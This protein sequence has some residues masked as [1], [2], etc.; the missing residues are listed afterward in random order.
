MLRNSRLSVHLVFWY[1]VLFVII[2]TTLVLLVNWQMRQQSLTEAERQASLLLDRNL[3]THTYFTHEL[4]PNIFKWTESFRSPDYFDPSWMSSTYAVRQM[5]KIFHQLA[6]EPYYYKES[7]INA[8]S[9]EA[10]ADDYEKGFLQELQKD[11]NLMRKTYIR[12]FDGQPYLT[13]LR[14]GEPMESSCMRCHTTPD[15]AP[16]GMVDIYGPDRSFGRNLDEVVQAISI[17]IPLAAAYA[18]ANKFSLHLSLLLLTLL[19]GGFGLLFVFTKRKIIT[20]IEQ[21]SNKA[22]LI[23]NSSE[24]LGETILEPQSSELKNLAQAFNMMSISLK[25]SMNEIEARVAERT[26][27]LRTKNVLLAEEIGERKRAEEQI[28]LNESRLQSLH[29]MSQYRAKN[30]QELLKFTLEHAIRLTGSKVGYMYHYDDS[31]QRFIL[32]TWTKNVMDQRDV[33]EPRDVYKLEE[34]GLW[35]EAAQQKKPVIVN[36]FQSYNPLEKGYPPGYGHVEFFKVLTVPVFQDDKVVAVVVVANKESDYNDSD[37][38]QLSLLMD[39]VWRMIE[40]MRAQDREQLL[41][42]AIEHA[43]EGI[44]ITDAT[45]IIQYVNS[46]EEDITGYSSGE[47]IGQKPSILKSGKHDDDLYRKLWETINAGKVWTGRFIN[48]RKDGTE[49]HE[50]ATISSV[51]NKAGDLTNFVA[52]KHDVTDHIKLQEQLIQ[53]QKMEAV[54]TL[55]G[56]ISHDFNNVLQPILGYSELLLQRKKEGE[57]D[58]ADIQKIYQAG[59][60]GADMIKSLM[61]FSRKTE[62]KFVPVDLNQ[63]ITLVQY[64]LS[65]TIPKNIKIDVHLSEVLE[66]IQGDSSQIGQVLMNL[67]VNARDAMPDGGTLSIETANI[68]LGK[69]NCITCLEEIKPGS[70]VLLTV[71]DTGQGMDKETLSHIFEPFFTTK[72]EGKGTGLGLATVYGIVKRHGGHISCYSEPGIGTSFKIYLPA[73]QTKKE[74]ETPT[75]EKAIPSGTGTILLVEDD[76]STRNLSATI[77][78]NFG[79]KVIT[80]GDGKEALE[81]YQVEKDRIDLIMLDLIMPIMDGKRCLEEILRVNPNAKVVIA[82]GYSEGG[83]ANWA[84]P[85]GAKGF[86][87]KPYDMRELLTRIREV[88]DKD[89]TG[90]D[91]G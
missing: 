56:G 81:I 75:F 77:L 13:V 15:L 14:R 50:D 43:A 38:I 78:N 33:A 60:R 47:F 73:I 55:A 1:T 5:D 40:S 32:N 23:A 86:V 16:K 64:L 12:Y 48:K 65:Q 44:I 61:T 39:S 62:T 34:T 22:I 27:E 26:A 89:I 35:G 20:P 90:P 4:K 9:P 68:Q 3:A 70:Y 24:H 28:K 37:I 36:D 79:Y 31:N 7:S 82:S 63:E 51:Y 67:G 21:I 76:E 8:R 2:A 10:E 42:A 52:V 59:L 80:A 46:A 19:L 66:S 29:E 18:G 45:G 11:S 84:T 69:E 88:L 53:S 74:L 83:P 49:Y 17:R 54:G 58:Y 87:Q 57:P 6:K 72:E 41:V 71:S 85:V 91:N 30:V 25:K